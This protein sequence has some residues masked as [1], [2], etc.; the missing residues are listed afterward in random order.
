MGWSEI[1]CLSNQYWIGHQI[2]IMNYSGNAI[3]RK[4]FHLGK[5]SDRQTQLVS[6]SA[7]L[8]RIAQ[9]FREY[10]PMYPLFRVTFRIDEN[11]S[12]YAGPPGRKGGS[13][14]GQS[15]LSIDINVSYVIANLMTDL[16]PSL[17]L[18]A[19]IL[20]IIQYLIKEKR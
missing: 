12:S 19:Y 3:V 1:K 8:V 13:S 2:D 11:T 17:H 9:T 4:V 6:Q 15:C 7:F 20:F 14:W 5:Q 18:F 16:I 10:F